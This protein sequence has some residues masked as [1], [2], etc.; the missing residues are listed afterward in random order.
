MPAPGDQY[1]GGNVTNPFEERV[2][3]GFTA[4]EIATLQSRLNKQLGPEYIST[5]PGNGGGKVAYLEGNKAIALANEVF[6][7]NGWSSSLGQVQIDYVDEHQNGKVSLGLSIVVRITLKDGTYHEDIGYGSIENGKGKAASF[8]KA[9]KEAATDGLKRSLRTFGNVL[10]NC[11]YDKE[12]L[13]KVQTMKVKPIKFEEGSLYRHATYAPRPQE[14]QAVVK[15]EPQRTPMR[16]NQVLRTRTEHLGE[17]FGA[18]FDD[19]FDGNLFD[20]VDV[21][22]G[23]GDEFSFDAGSAPAESAPAPM[24]RAVEAVRSTNGANGANGVRSARTSPIRQTGPPRQ[25]PPRMQPANGINGQGPPQNRPNQGPGRPSPAG[26]M[27]RQPQTPVQPQNQ[28]R[29]DQNGGRMPP[30]NSN[31]SAN[32]APRPPVQQNQQPQNQPLRNTP[33]DAQHAPAQPRPA[34]QAQGV[35]TP[36]ANPAPP[37]GRPPVGFI[38]SRAAELLQNSD[39]AVPSIAHLPTFN[40]NAESPVPKDKRTPGIDN[41]RSA[42]VK[43]EQVGAPP[44]PPPAAEPANSRPSRPSN[45]VNPQQDMN[46][47]IGMPGAPSYA[48][49]PS[50]NR[51]AYKPPTFANGAAGVKRERPPLQDV[52]NQGANAGI[53]GPDVKRQRV[54]GATGT[55]NGGP[56]GS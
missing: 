49:S 19:E 18:E 54:E 40:P 9:K 23:H 2:V 8:E 43:R 3:N 21:T 20:G 22:E 24:P 16:P 29:P 33:P 7:F 30:P 37:N 11:L 4:S 50:A 36:S 34:P 42:P 1:H 14:E 52:S 5:R 13:K 41:R 44:A 26:P 38:T 55:E 32:M 35:T 31:N 48:M 47:R 6:G 53:E 10:G 39:A 45:F 12:Y 17:S 51:G 25:P 15:H 56:V 46:R 27:Q 28:Q